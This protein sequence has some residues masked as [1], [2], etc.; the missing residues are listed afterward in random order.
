MDPSKKSEKVSIDE[1]SVLQLSDSLFPTG[2]YT[3]SNGLETYFYDKKIRS[4]NQV[5]DLTKVFLTQQVGPVDCVAIGNSYQA[6][7]ISDI[8]KLIEIDQTIFAMRLLQDVR[9]ASTRSGNQILKCISSFI[10]NT[11]N[12]GV[13][14]NNDNSN[15]TAI[16]YRY[17]EAIKEARASGIYPVALAVVSSIFG[18]PSYKSAVMMLYSFTAS[19]IGASLRLGMLNHFDGQRIIHELKPVILETVDTNIDRPLTGI[20][21]FAPGIDIT[22]MKHER[23]AS[24][25]FIT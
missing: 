19:M 21:Q 6:I 1:I 3:M 24:K 13:A 18:I 11:N 10:N 7:L 12:N 4:A 15:S 17:Q 22:Q 23:A 8:Q 16:L 14:G 5:R 20:W 9:N 25:M 2:M